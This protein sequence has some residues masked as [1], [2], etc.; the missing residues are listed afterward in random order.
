MGSPAGAL[1]V[2]SVSLPPVSLPPVA[3]PVPSTVQVGPLVVTPPAVEA[4][5]DGVHV[6]VP[7]PSDG[8]NQPGVIGVDVGPDG[9]DI[10]FP[11][12]LNLP[13][14]IADGPV[15]AVP[16]SPRLPTRT[17]AEIQAA[18]ANGAEASVAPAAPR[19][20]EFRA[21]S[22]NAQPEA[23]IVNGDPAGAT[24]ALSD[25]RGGGVWSLLSSA[26]HSKVAW[27]L[28]IALALVARLVAAW[29][30]RDALRPVT[31]AELARSRDRSATA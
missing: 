5:S 26:A 11:D 9:T 1:E 28:L 14:P 31:E 24:G 12:G 19:A 4:G 17:P 8:T 21:P 16:T 6:D 2:P 25:N 23:Q 18:R 20:P 3:V 30:W 13:D 10:S 7:L 27:A 22:A 15:P 29:A